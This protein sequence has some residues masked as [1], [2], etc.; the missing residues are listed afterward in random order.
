MKSTEMA[1]AIRAAACTPAKS[2]D[3][4]GVGR[5]YRFAADF[6]GFDGHFPGAP[7]LPAI[8]QI[9]MGR[10]L[11]E[12][13]LES[14]LQLLAVDHAKFLKPVRPGELL[15]LECRILSRDGTI[16]CEVRLACDDQPVAGFRLSLGETER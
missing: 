15:R 2:L 16:V 5:G 6:I 3:G 12:E 13:W 1:A 4:N 11:V 8:A 9:E 14:P 10:Q 7:I